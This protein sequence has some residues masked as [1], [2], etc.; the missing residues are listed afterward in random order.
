MQFLSGEMH[1]NKIAGLH[2]RAPYLCAE[3][4]L[5][6]GSPRHANSCVCG[7]KKDQAAAIESTRLGTSESIGLADHGCCAVDHDL[8]LRRFLLGRGFSWGRD[9]R[10]VRGLLR[11]PLRGCR[12]GGKH[13]R[14]HACQSRLVQDR[15]ADTVAAS[16]APT[17][18]ASARKVPTHRRASQCS[19][20]MNFSG[21]SVMPP[22]RTMRS[23][24]NRE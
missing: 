8:G 20:S 12:A 18:P 21:S 22:H 4:Q 7:G 3:F 17:M 6:G 5:L 14:A 9:F 11:G 16:A 24:H 1:E 10:R 2:F 23:G 19:L 13:E 15:V